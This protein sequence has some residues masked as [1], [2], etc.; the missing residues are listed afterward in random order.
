MWA[1]IA[2]PRY[3]GFNEKK[4][5]KPKIKP[6]PK[7]LK[8]KIDRLRV[9]FEFLEDYGGYVEIAGLVLAPFT[10]GASLGVA[11]VGI[12][13][14]GVGTTGNVILDIIEYK[15]TNDPVKLTNARNRVLKYGL[16]LGTGKALEKLTFNFTDKLITKFLDVAIDKGILDNIFLTN[17]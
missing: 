1:R 14:T 2:N 15:Y 3:R 17:K 16:T 7:E 12:V 8:E 11:G 9:G 5:I 6:L 4:E 10:E 13:F